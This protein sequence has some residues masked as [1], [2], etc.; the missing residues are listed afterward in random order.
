MRRNN[1]A[2]PRAPVNERI[3]QTGSVSPAEQSRSLEEPRDS[4]RGARFKREDSPRRR[5]SGDSVVLSNDALVDAVPSKPRPRAND[6]LFLHRG[7]AILGPRNRDG[8]LTESR[9]KQKGSSHRI[10]EALGKASRCIEV[11][12]GKGRVQGE[13]RNRDE[14]HCR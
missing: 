1:D 6:A 2:S 14:L 11:P 7:A 12:I 10:F 9:A 13:R 3:E 5:I 4:T 8:S